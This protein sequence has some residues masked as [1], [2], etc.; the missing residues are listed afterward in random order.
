VEYYSSID[1]TTRILL[2]EFDD[3][4]AA[5][6]Y[7]RRFASIAAVNGNVVMS[8]DYKN[9]AENLRIEKEARILA[10]SRAFGE[11]PL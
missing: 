3:I 2:Q 6:S 8:M 5:I 4:D 10:N 9:A 7:A 11:I 1:P